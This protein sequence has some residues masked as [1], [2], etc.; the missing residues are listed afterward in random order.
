MVFSLVKFSHALKFF[1]GAQDFYGLRLAM[2]KRWSVPSREQ[3][4]DPSMQASLIELEKS[5]R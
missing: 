2:G 5:A 4:P 1:S 3:D